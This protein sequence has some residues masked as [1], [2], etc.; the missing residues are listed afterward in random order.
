MYVNVVLLFGGDG[1]E[2]EIS[3]RS[4]AAVLPHLSSRHTVRTVGIDRTGAWLLTATSPKAIAADAWQEGGIPVTPHFGDHALLAGGAP[5]PCDVIFPLLHGGLGEGGG[6]AALLSLLSIPYVGC[7]PTAGMLGMDKRLAKRLAADAGIRVAAYRTVGRDELADPTLKGALGDALGYPMFVKP[8][9]G[10]S[11]VGAARVDT[12]EGLLPAL[13]SALLHSDTALCEEYIAGAEVELAIL[14][15]EDGLFGT[16]VGEIDP[17]AP[18]YDYDAKYRDRSSRLFIPARISSAARREV[19][20]AGHT[21]FRLFGCRGLARVDFFVRD[22]E[23]IFNE[24]NTMPGFTDIS[25]YP[26]LLAAAGFPIGEVLDTLLVGA[27]R[28]ARDRGL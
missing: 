17:G 24:I 12:E 23:V 13:D 18:F 14:E 28:H 7:P 6:V 10:G 2:Y 27:Y 21:L 9:S 25:M 1:A 22:G 15:R 8:T 4:A 20:E 3:L 11:S 5:I 19:A 16:L 26:R